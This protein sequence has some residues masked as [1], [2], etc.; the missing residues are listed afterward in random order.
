MKQNLK[1]YVNYLCMI[2]GFILLATLAIK[3]MN[4]PLSLSTDSIVSL[5]TPWTF[6][7]DGT[8][9]EIDLPITLSIAPSEDCVV[10]NT[11]PSTLVNDA[12]LLIRTSHQSIRVYIED[13][14]IYERGID[15]ITFPGKALGSIWNLVELS[16]AYAGKNISIVLNSP[17]KNYA[18][19]VREISY[20]SCMGNFLSIFKEHGTVFIFDIFLLSFGIFL[21]ILSASLK[22]RNYEIDTLLYFSEFSIL[23]SLWLLGES[24]ML[25][26]FISNL[27]LVTLT[28][29]MALWLFPIPFVL[30]FE[31]ACNFHSTICKKVVH[32]IFYIL[33]FDFIVC[34]LMHFLNIYTYSQSLWIHHLTLAFGIISLIIIS[35]YEAIKFRS[36]DT[37]KILRTLAIFFFF[38]GMEILEYNLTASRF[39]VTGYLRIG[40]LIVTLI[41][42]FESVSKIEKVS[43]Q[44]KEQLYY[45]RL[46]YIDLVTLG[47]NRN[48]YMEELNE[49]Y[50]NKKEKNTAL[51][52]FD[53]NDLKEINDSLGHLAGDDAIKSA[54]DCIHSV[55]GNFG[56]C[57]RIGG[58][59]FACILRDTN[60]P[61][62][63]TLI[64]DF[65]QSIA[66]MDA[67][68]N[69]PLEIALGYSFTSDHLNE[70]NYLDL[71]DFADKNMYLDKEKLKARA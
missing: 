24:R 65:R 64:L 31:Q 30:F 9:V 7:M 56:T 49:I 42:C 69:Y 34:T 59:E 51:I 52:L 11:L 40:Y 63:E 26:F 41:I 47:K 23:F 45:Q 32:T 58:D 18:G 22:R 19:L 36:K 8:E 43:S 68:K 48:A 54:F 57:Y 62:I 27:S 4:F 46:A 50:K 29:L 44:K 15:P 25:Q 67:S 61:L 60:P 53:L 2:I 55:F 17:Y 37:L 12:S 38:S 13:E 35:L 16:D 70:K 33:S 14:L 5:E 39:V 1:I 20:A 28:Y 21:L 66:A 71:Y 10:H 3:Y 6:D